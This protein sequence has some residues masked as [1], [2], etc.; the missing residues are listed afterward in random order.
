MDPLT[1]AVT[2]ATA[3]YEAAED[4]GSVKETSEELKA[5]Q[6]VFEAN[7]M[8]KRLLLVPTIPATEK[9]KA[10]GAVFEGR[11]SDIM[12]NFLYILIEKRRI[13]SWDGIVLTYSRIKDERDGL[14]KGII[15][16]VIPIAKSKLAA[17]EEEVGSLFSK[18]VK[19]ENRIDESLLGGVRIYVE[20]KLIDISIRHKL[21]Q[22]KQAMLEKQ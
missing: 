8:L 15:Y 13:S 14:T 20:G 6:E 4:S 9:K 2:Y 19:L 1:V 3:L 10:A 7:P 22:M 21:E 16:S 17:F 5:L 11:L 12:M 18:S